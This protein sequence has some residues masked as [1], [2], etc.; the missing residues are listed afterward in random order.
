[1]MA[2]RR[3]VTS[4]RPLQIPITQNVIGAGAG[5]WLPTHL[6]YVRRFTGEHRHQVVGGFSAGFADELLSLGPA[7]CIGPSHNGGGI[8]FLQR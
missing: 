2:S 4:T 3:S 6:E 7:G 5:F 8:G 1:M